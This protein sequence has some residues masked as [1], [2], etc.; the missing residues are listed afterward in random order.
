MYG[1]YRFYVDKWPGIIQASSVLDIID[2]FSVELRAPFNRLIHTLYSPDKNQP[3]VYNEYTN[4][5]HDRANFCSSNF[6]PLL[7][8]KYGEVTA[9]S[10]MATC[11]NNVDSIYSLIR[12]EV[13]LPINSIPMILSVD[14]DCNYVLNSISLNGY[15][16][17]ISRLYAMG[18]RVNNSFYHVYNMKNTATTL[19]G[20][21]IGSIVAFEDRQIIKKSV[22]HRSK[23]CVDHIMDVFGVNSILCNSISDG[24]KDK[25]TNLVGEYFVD[26]VGENFIFSL[27]CLKTITPNYHFKQCHVVNKLRKIIK[28]EGL[29]L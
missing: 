20:G 18:Y 23:N 13:Q 7:I 17:F 10:V 21:Q 8:G 28:S 29:L 16:R 1:S 4:N 27:P 2:M 11:N 9:P 15:N 12:I 6:T 5:I 24:A 25:I 19:D 3:I 22:V 26:T 14:F